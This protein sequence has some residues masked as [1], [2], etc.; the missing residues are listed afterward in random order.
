MTDWKKLKGKNVTV[1]AAGVV[2]RG[3]VVELG[4]GTLLLRAAGG[5]REIP[6]ETISRVVEGGAAPPK[7]P[8][9]LQAGGS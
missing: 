9:A 6:W 8:S 5:F 7:Q 3:T 1:Y 2:Y 4:I